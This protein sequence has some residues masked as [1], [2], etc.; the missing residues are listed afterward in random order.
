MQ[1][2]LPDDLIDKP[3]ER[4]ELERREIAHHSGREREAL[5]P[6]RGEKVPRSGG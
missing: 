5:L 6:A 4:A 3:Q 2:E 1:I